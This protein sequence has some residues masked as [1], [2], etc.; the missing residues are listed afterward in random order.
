MSCE[1]DDSFFLV[2]PM[3]AFASQ[4]PRSQRLSIPTT[5]DRLLDRP[6]VLVGP[7]RTK[8]VRLDFYCS[9]AFCSVEFLSPIDRMSYAMAAK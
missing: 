5:D 7:V 1:I 2:R 8:D 3:I 4:S 9:Q 6:S